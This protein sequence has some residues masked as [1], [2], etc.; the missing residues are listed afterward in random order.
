M[1][2]E[3]VSPISNFVLLSI[4]CLAHLRIYLNALIFQAAN[5][6]P[7]SINNMYAQFNKQN[8]NLVYNLMRHSYIKPMLF[9]EDVFRR[10]IYL[11]N[12]TYMLF[13]V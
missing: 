1:E 4:T 5:C 7:S 8:I 6:Q 13:C 10:N 9:K 11:I 3:F 2:F 12:R